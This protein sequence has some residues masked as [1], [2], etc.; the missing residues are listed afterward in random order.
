M[1]GTVIDVPLVGQ[2]Y[3]LK[4]WSID[5]Q[6]TLNFYPQVV[7]SGNTPQVS[8]LLPTPGLIKLFEFDSY[9]RGLYAISDKLFVVAGQKLLLV[10]TDN[11][12]TELGEVSGVGRVYFADNSVQLMIV[13]NNTYSYNLVQNTLTKLSLGE[14]FGAS[15]VTVLDSRFI[16]TVPKSDRFQWSGLLTTDTTAL[17]YATAEAKSDKL[18]RT[19]ENNGLLWLIGEK[20]TEIWGSTGSSNLPFQRMS[21]AVL[22]T[23]CIAP[24][25]VCRFGSSLVWLTQTEHGQGQIVM[26]E[27]YAA[28]RISNH[29]IESDILSYSDISDAYA[30]TYQEN[31][32]AFL[33]MTFPKAKK[34]WCF[35]I[36]TQMWHERSYFNPK[37]SLHEH[38]RA[39]V[40]CFFNG[41]HIV[42]DRQNGKLYKLT[43]D[44]NTDDG[45][46]IVRER[47]TPVI[48]PQI[49]R[50]IF[51]ELEV[52]AQVGQETNSKPEMILDWSDD[53]GKTWSYSRQHDLGAIG[54]YGR[55]IIFRRLG[56]SFGRVFRLRMSD[57][58]RFVL[59][60][61]KA[62]VSV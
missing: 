16:W 59:L 31:G 50:M 25:S 6:R 56:Q 43:Q 37:T 38:H 41:M 15:D 27:G 42:G 48:N 18:V 8:A 35:D 33:I 54:Q 57:A 5:C 3:H 52:I 12:V 9:I 39:F 62:K 47:I 7:E 49:Q 13:S 51:H 19:I 29:A 53:K 24:N 21:G 28:K 11:S 2:S 17:S 30:F 26:T 20:T 32:H 44:S 36:A 45:S 14:F 34:T 46:V 40:H 58:S 23:G 4:D 61:A 22:P 60:G 10:K 55:R 1:A